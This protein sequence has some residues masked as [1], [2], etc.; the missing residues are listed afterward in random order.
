M[1]AEV[2]REQGASTPLLFR[3]QL[4]CPRAREFDEKLSARIFGQEDAI[5]DMSGLYQLY[6]FLLILL[7]SFRHAWRSDE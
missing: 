7:I 4:K 3:P 2:R 1:F 6:V 5:H